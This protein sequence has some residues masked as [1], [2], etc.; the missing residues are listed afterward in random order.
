MRKDILLKILNEKSMQFTR[1]EINEMLDAELEK[2]P[3]EM[4]TDF[5]DL[6]LDALESEYPDIDINENKNLIP[7]TPPQSITEESCE[8][9][10]LEKNV[11][12]TKSKVRKIKFIK[13]IAIIAAAVTVLAF[14]ITVGAKIVDIDASNDLVDFNGK[15]F[16]ISLFNKDGA[17]DK[18]NV[19]NELTD[20]GIENVVL[21]NEILSDEYIK[22]N[23][24]YEDIY[25]NFEF[26]NEQN[27]IE[28]SLSI[29]RI[30]ADSNSYTAQSQVNE[31]YYKVEQIENSGIDILV[32]ESNKNTMIFYVEDNMEYTITLANCDFETAKKIAESIKG[33]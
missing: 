2:S 8:E 33:V 16:I 18:V 32:F 22:Y 3:E 23:F 7:E 26:K 11:K 21:P 17:S 1:E 19:V 13:S 5:V 31:S 28:G 29:N 6:C 9:E 14:T 12:D 24:T 20:N 27:G 4:D 10:V 15:N 25:S 30:N